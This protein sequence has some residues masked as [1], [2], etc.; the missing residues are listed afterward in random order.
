MGT[1]AQRIASSYLIPYLSACSYLQ[2]LVHD[3]NFP[4]SNQH[5][6]CFGAVEESKA[7]ERERQKAAKEEAERRKAA[8]EERKAK[9]ATRKLKQ[10]EARAVAAVSSPLVCV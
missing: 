4:I 5:L 6:V 3:I 10:R 1:T 2:P 7:A 9:E 8:A